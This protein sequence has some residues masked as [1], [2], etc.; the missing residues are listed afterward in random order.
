ME[1]VGTTNFEQWNV[2]AFCSS[3]ITKL[4][5]GKNADMVFQNSSEESCLD[6]HKFM[7]LDI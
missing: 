1:N 7:A 4:L 3:N 6:L 2:N 5:D